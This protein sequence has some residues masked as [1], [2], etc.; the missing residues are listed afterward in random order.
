MTKT[1]I[2]S[3]GFG[4]R[5]DSRGMFP[6]IAAAFPD[7]KFK[8]FD[9]NVVDEN[10]DTTVRSLDQ[11]A[12]ILQRQIDK[13]QGGEIVLLCHSQGSVIAGLVD[14][15]KVSKVVLL[16][17]P[18]RMSMQNLIRRMQ[19]REGSV[20]RPD[21]VSVLPRSDGTTSYL[22]KEYLQSLENRNPIE[23]YQQV[24]N[25][26]PTSIVRATEDEVIGLTNIN[27]I[28]NAK[29]IDIAADHNFTGNMRVRLIETLRGIL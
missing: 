12:E 25:A 19:S 7:Y 3:H 22:P 4:V 5:A 15:T 26:K 18:V 14:L 9:Y 16:A 24:A 8:M 1:I 28:E 27:E 2:C 21:G 11:Q 23:L 13:A 10:G 20:I 17:P 6:E 29:H